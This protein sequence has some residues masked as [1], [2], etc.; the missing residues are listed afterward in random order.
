M[1]FKQDCKHFRAFVKGRR[2]GMAAGQAAQPVVTY[3]CEKS[4][5]GPQVSIASWQ[6]RSGKSPCED[7]PDYESREQEA[8][9]KKRSWWK[10]G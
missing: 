3:D 10:R 5:F 7:C 1:D 2:I 4:H 8:H 6:T 9:P